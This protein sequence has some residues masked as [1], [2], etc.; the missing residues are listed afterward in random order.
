MYKFSTLLFL[1]GI[2]S[3]SFGQKY[4]TADIIKRADSLIISVVGQNVFANNYTLDST[5]DIESW[6]KTYDKEK[7]IKR[8]VLNSKITR[9]FS[10]I[11]IDYVFYINKYERPFF[12][13]RILLDKNLNAQFSIDTTFIPKYILRGTKND[14]LQESDAL[15]IAKAKLIR[16][17]IKPFE[18]SLTY[19]YSKKIYVWTVLNIINESKDNNIN[20]WRDVEF[21]E[22]NALTGQILNYQFDA[23]QGSLH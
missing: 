13:T 22:L 12:P 6:Q 2:S 5:K 18:A 19:D 16:P 14:M 23:L 7:K 1:F 4:K 3:T 21:L 10:L 11:A 17:G 15:K 9:H 8:L 20:P